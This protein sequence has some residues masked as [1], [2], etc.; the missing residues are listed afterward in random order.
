MPVI[1]N[2]GVAIHYEAEGSQGPVVVMVHGMGMSAKDW[3]RAGY[4]DALRDEYRLLVIDSRGFGES[5]KPPEPAAYGRH[6]KVSDI[7]AV[8][9]AE[10]VDQA[11]YWGFSMGASIGWAFG[12]LTPERARSLIIGAYPVLPATVTESDRLRWESRAELMRLGM[13]VYVTAMEMHNGP[14]DP[15]AKQR[16]LANDGMSYAAQQI[17]NLSWGVPD[18]DVR[19]M[20]LPT[21]VYTGTEDKDVMPTN[22]E[23]TV[24]TAGLAPNAT[25]LQIPGYKHMQTFN[26]S[27]FIIPHVR[28][29]IANVDSEAK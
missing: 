29:W 9:D 22:H 10:G 28:E 24:R 11:H 23:L 16:L 19:K 14:M 15:D 25:L 1:D 12:M 17:A 5:G 27:E 4:I 13:N 20:T 21:F 7:I 26:D 8:L 2:N 3:Y 6:E 18:D